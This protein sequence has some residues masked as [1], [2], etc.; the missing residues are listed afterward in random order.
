MKRWLKSLPLIR[1]LQDINAKLNNLASHQRLIETTAI[2]QA[3]EA[4]KNSHPRYRDPQRLLI[5]GA[6][7]WSQ[8]YEDG[9]IA[10]IFRR[11]GVSTRTFLEIG[12]GDGSENNTTALLA[13]GWHGWWIDGSEECAQKIH[14]RLR[15]MPELAARL[16][17]RQALVGTDNIADLLKQLGVP[18][19]IDL[20]SLDIDLNTYHIWAALKGFRPRVVVVEYNAGLGPENDWIH[21]YEPSK[22]WDYTQAFGASLEAYVRLGA[23]FGY[24]LVG[25]DITGLNAFF[26][27]DDLLGEHFV[28][29]FTSQ[30]H[31][32]PARYS[33]WGRLG[34]M[35]VF[36]GERHK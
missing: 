13:A 6:Q 5:H 19:E 26:V 17:M 2:I 3:L 33:L 31:Y 28:G 35:S 8:N 25:C 15:A 18:V 7:Y 23:Q 21:P 22:V 32:E 16:K 29:P 24:S 20:F 36:Y 34:H 9:M 1:D 30:N 10:E 11:I 12:V 4:I 14:E 27:R